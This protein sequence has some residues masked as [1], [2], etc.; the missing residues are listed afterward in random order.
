MTNG[1]HRPPRRSKAR[2]RRTTTGFHIRRL[3]AVAVL[4]AA[5]IGLLYAVPS[6]ADA[7]SAGSTANTAPNA[8]TVRRMDYGSGTLGNWQALTHG[9]VGDV[10]DTPYDGDPQ[11]EVL[12]V[13]DSITTRSYSALIGALQDAG[14]TAAVN[15][16]S[17]RPTAPAVDWVLSLSTKPKVIVMATGS[18]DVMDPPVMAAQIARLQAG[19]P[20]T[21]TLL[22]VDVQVSRP[23]YALADQRNS[24]AVNQQ[25]YAALSPDHVIYWSQMF[26]SAPW[27]LSYYLQDGVHPWIGAA[28]GHGDGVA[29]RVATMLPKIIAAL[30]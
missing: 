26:W 4:A 5:T 12:I 25:I 30:G 19:L 6:P 2:H 28:D 1:R 16:W 11:A 7:R 10:V 21:T 3:S 22:W 17:G 14:H 13:G 24:M 9:T 20:A 8:A 29:F 15:Y 23:A 18:N 27:R